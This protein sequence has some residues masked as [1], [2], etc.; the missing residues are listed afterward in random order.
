[1][2]QQSLVG[3]G[4][5]IIEA[6]QSHSD[7]QAH[8][9]THTHTHISRGGNLS[10]LNSPRRVIRP[11]EGS[12]L[13]STRHSQETDMHSFCG[14]RTCNPSKRAAADP[15][16]RLRGHLHWPISTHGNH[17]FLSSDPILLC[18][19]IHVLPLINFWCFFL[20]TI[21]WFLQFYLKTY[22]SKFF[23]TLKSVF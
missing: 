19:Y 22:F 13:Y 18:F 11:T 5:I 14:I 8:A 4:L 7:T 23:K 3:Q 10:R 6:W 15:H 20:A 16:L 2:A 12:L 17:I 9:H 1:M 21:H